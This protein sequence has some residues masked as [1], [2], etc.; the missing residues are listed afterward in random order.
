MIDTTDIYEKLS[1][2]FRDVF[3]DETLIAKPS[4]TADDIAGW[5]SLTNL[6]LVLTVQKAFGVKFTAHEI[7]S[8]NNVGE[9]ATLVQAKI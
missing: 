4:L 6:R 2:I 1:V 3:E 5:D 9:L 7:T 8:L